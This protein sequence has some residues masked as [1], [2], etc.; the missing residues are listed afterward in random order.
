[1]ALFIHYL[2]LF[3]AQVVLQQ[4]ITTEKLDIVISH[5]SYI[6][7]LLQVSKIFTVA[8]LMMEHRFLLI[9]EHTR[10]KNKS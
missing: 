2:L 3:I 8:Q 6:Y 1:M 5:A 10:K 7:R 9:H 4:S